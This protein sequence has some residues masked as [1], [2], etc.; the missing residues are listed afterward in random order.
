[1]MKASGW[2]V[3]L[4]VVLLLP[5]SFSTRSHVQSLPQARG[6]AQMEDGREGA[7]LRSSSYKPP[8][9]RPFVCNPSPCILPNED[10]STGRGIH[11]YHLPGRMGLDRN[12]RTDDDGICWSV[13]VP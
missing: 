10:A 2:L 6:V 7:I 1:M 12:G 3:V 13:I 9:K 4:L 11:R 5:L 8:I